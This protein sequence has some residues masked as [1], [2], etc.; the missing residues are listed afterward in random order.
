MASKAIAY[1]YVHM[2][3]YIVHVLSCCVFGLHHNNAVHVHILYVHVLALRTIYTHEPLYK[4]H[5][6]TA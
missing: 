2:L 6:Y 5:V 3:T 4:G 1:A